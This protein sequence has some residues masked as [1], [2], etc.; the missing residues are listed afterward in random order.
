MFS[1]TALFMLYYFAFAMPVISRSYSLKPLIEK[2]LEVS[3]KR[4]PIADYYKWFRRSSS[5]WLKNDITFLKQDKEKSVLRFFKKPGTQYVIMKKAEKKRFVNLM[6]RLGKT[7]TL[8]KRGQKNLLMRVT[9]KG[10]VLDQNAAKKYRPKSLPSDMIPT[11]AVFDKVAEL[12]G[13]KIIKGELENRE[14]KLWAK[15]G[16]TIEIALY[17][18]ALQSNIP[19]DYMVFLHTEG[20]KKDMRTKGDENMAMGTYPTTYWKKGD[21]IR[22][23]LSVRIP[24]NSKNDYYIPYVGL[25]QEDYRSNI[26]NFK[27]VP[28]DGDNRLE[29]MKIWLIKQ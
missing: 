8:V 27:D 1:V 24:A 25:Y 4:E 2:Y 5:F 14:G 17:F 13:Y 28:N 22:H 9:G 6:K 23:P 12:V 19:K 3:P 21:L 7:V 18:K 16:Q 15:G 29:L 26:T 10:R 11:H 20:D